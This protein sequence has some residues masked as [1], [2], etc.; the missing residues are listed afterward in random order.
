MDGSYR[1]FI[2]E[3]ESIRESIFSNNSRTKK[4]FYRIR[5]NII[6]IPAEDEI[7]S[8]GPDMELYMSVSDTALIGPSLGF[9]VHPYKHFLVNN[10][11]MDE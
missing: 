1:F 4:L 3:A 8:F 9:Y 6:R 2:H 7:N 11:E 5:N 10:M